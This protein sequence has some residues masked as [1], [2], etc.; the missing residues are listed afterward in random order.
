MEMR[1]LAPPTHHYFSGGV[2]TKD[3][4][5]LFR[6]GA[7]SVKG[8]PTHSLLF[9]RVF[10]RYPNFVRVPWVLAAAQTHTYLLTYIKKIKWYEEMAHG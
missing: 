9:F 1:L 2:S 5:Y 8:P 4:H 3:R 6:L 10:V 7:L